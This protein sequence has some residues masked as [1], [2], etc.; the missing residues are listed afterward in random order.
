MK[1]I[2]IVTGAS[3]G[4]GAEFARQLAAGFRF[5]RGEVLDEL[6]LVARRRDRLEELA[7]GLAA[8]GAAASAGGPVP[9]PRPVVIEADLATADGCARVAARLTAERPRVALLVNNAGYGSY[10]PFSDTEKD[11]QLGQIDINCRG[12]SDLCWS[13]LPW[14]DRGSRLINVASLAAFSALG[15][16]AV[17]A[18]TKA[19]VLSFSAALRAELAPRGII[20]T[21][22]CP[23]SVSTGFAAVA[24][25]GARAEVLHGHPAAAVVQSC[26]RHS[27]RGR[28]L[29]LHALDWKLTAFASRL[30]GRTLIAR[31]TWRFH[32]RPQ[33]RTVTR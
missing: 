9:A 33:A 20:V 11:F 21:A 30:A 29:S 4:I 28:F 8:S 17:Y 2:A 3:S 13:A 23:G 7:A 15:N 26:L 19:Y 27:R 22:L 6:W 1:T 16:F 18:A 5:K 31:L 12:L 32:K 25:G 14:M 10:G 24:S